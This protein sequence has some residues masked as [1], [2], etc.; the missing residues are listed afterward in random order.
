MNF[1]I[2]PEERRKSIYAHPKVSSFYIYG[3]PDKE[4]F[5]KRILP[6]ILNILCLTFHIAYL[7]KQLYLVFVFLF[8]LVFFYRSSLLWMLYKR[9]YEKCCKIQR[10]YLRQRSATLIKR[11]SITTFPRNIEKEFQN[12]FFAEQQLL[13][14]LDDW[15]SIQ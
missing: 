12:T 4:Y 2:T 9:C 11:D 5:F 7:T 1:D 8:C 3:I 15:Y 14:T 13:L 10:K 6:S